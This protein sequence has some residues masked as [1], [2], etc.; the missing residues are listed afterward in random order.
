MN[1]VHKNVPLFHVCDQCGVV[2][3]PKPEA[4]YFSYFGLSPSFFIDQD[5]VTKEFFKISRVLHPDRFH[6]KTDLL[7]EATRVFALVNKA[8]AT[9]KS[10]VER[11]RHLFELT[12]FSLQQQK[13]VLPAELAATY[14]D[15]QETLEAPSTSP[16]TSVEAKAKLVADFSKQV[17]ELILQSETSRDNAFREWEKAGRPLDQ[18][19]SPFFEKAAAE[20]NRRNYLQSIARDMARDLETKCP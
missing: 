10:P 16:E 3:A 9:L 4:D 2:N 12:H 18:R 19:A 1:C 15:L 11:A 7:D 13:S 8:L 6:M 14:F 20:I 17:Q 5:H